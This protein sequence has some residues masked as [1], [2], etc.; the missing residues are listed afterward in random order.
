MDN[1]TKEALEPFIELALIT[2]VMYPV[3]SGKEATV[4]ACRAHPNTGTEWLAAKV[5]KHLRERSFRNDAAYQENRTAMYHNTR[6]RRAY[7][8]GSEFGLEAPF[9][10]WV[11]QEWEHLT[12][13]HR[14]GVHVPVP[15]KHAGRAIL[16]E[17]FGTKDGPCPTL[18]QTK[19][20]PARAGE[21]WN[22]LKANIEMMLQ[23]DCVHG[24][25][26]PYNILVDLDSSSDPLRIIDLPQC[27]DARFNANARDLLAHD[28]ETTFHY[29]EKLG[30]RDNPRAFMADLWQRWKRAEL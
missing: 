20:P 17:F 11:G 9:M 14:T 6:V 18:Q 1:E 27:V 4:Y 13:L 30:V 28:V 5:Y 10:L 29:F 15:V 25:L 24:D 16:M 7:E 2:E 19:V 26:S 3:K 23:A 22:L 8:N 21:L 12:K